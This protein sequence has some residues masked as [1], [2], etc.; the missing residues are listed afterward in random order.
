MSYIWTDADQAKY[1]YRSRKQTFIHALIDLIKDGEDDEDSELLE[2]L[3]NAREKEDAVFERIERA[4][5][6]L[7][8]ELSGKEFAL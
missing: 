1:E 3:T 7:Q 5:I 2:A 4:S 6:Q 8:R